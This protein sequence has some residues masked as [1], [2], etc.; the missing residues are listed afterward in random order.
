[1]TIGLF[2]FTVLS[3]SLIGALILLKLI[4]STPALME[5]ISKAEEEEIKVGAND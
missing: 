4:F 1:M 3:L 5:I 2:I